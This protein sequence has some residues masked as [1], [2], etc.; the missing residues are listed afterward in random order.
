MNALRARLSAAST[1]WFPPLPAAR[2]AW[3]RTILYGFVFVDVLI[4]TSWVPMHAHTPLELYRPLWLARVLPLPAPGPVVVPAVMTALLLCAAIALTG[5]LPRIAGAAVFLLY[6]RWMLI[7]FSYG[8][9][10]HDRFALLA[11]LAVLPTAGAAS[12]RDTVRSDAAGWAIRCIQVAVVAT[13]FLSAF[14][15][16]RYGGLE[17][18][19]GSTLMRGVLRRGTVIGDQLRHYPGLLHAAQYGIVAFELSSPVLLVKGAVGR[20]Y[21]ALAGLFHLVTWVTLKI[22]FLP[23]TVCLIAFLPL[24]R[25]PI[26]SISLDVPRSIRAR[27]GER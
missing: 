1:W 9:V 2:L 27:S 23:H 15:K 3:L 4:T 18:L 6:L 13:Y 21:L 24:E 14:A 16:L 7:A 22:T 26:P 25:L 17:W 10:N 12:H 8:K 11:A 20:I 19:D 5:R